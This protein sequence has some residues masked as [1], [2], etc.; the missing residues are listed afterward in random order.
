MGCSASAT[1]DKF[2]D[3]SANIVSSDEIHEDELLKRI[4]KLEEYRKGQSVTSTPESLIVFGGTAANSKEL[5]D[6]VWQYEFQKRTWTVLNCFGDAPLSRAFHSAVY[7][8]GKLWIIG[9]L[10]QNA[11]HSDMYCM[12]LGTK[13][14]Q[15]V[16]Q[17][18]HCRENRA[19]AWNNSIIIVHDAEVGCRIS[20]SRYDIGAGVW[21][22]DS[23]P[24]AELAPIRP[25][26]TLMFAIV[27]SHLFALGVRGH[28]LLRYELET[29]VW[30]SLSFSG[31]D[32]GFGIGS[33]WFSSWAGCLWFVFITLLEAKPVMYLY[34][35]LPIEEGVQNS[36]KSYLRRISTT[37]LLPWAQTPS[38]LQAICQ[39]ELSIC[40]TDKGI[41]N[42]FAFSYNSPVL[43][44]QCG[45][46]V[47]EGNPRR[48]PSLS[49]REI[50]PEPL[51]RR[52]ISRPR[53]TRARTRSTELDFDSELRIDT[54][55][56]PQSRSASNTSCSSAGITDSSASSGLEG[57]DIWT[58]QGH[59]SPT[60]S[61][62]V[63]RNSALIDESSGSPHLVLRFRCNAH[64][65]SVPN[66]PPHLHSPNF[67]NPLHSGHLRHRATLPPVLPPRPNPPS[68]SSHGPYRRPAFCSVSEPQ[69]S[70]PAAPSGS[71]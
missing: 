3:F 71:V 59:H 48:S 64:A 24:F 61:V 25:D 40:I 35:I 36:F 58:P 7:H 9:G 51:R 20:V 46:R 32:V 28:T 50:V 38:N 70:L 26:D 31:M 8:S 21:K 6:Q 62:S 29:H 14:W 41:L 55:G 10:S 57:V 63:P 17:A 11:Q 15:Y 34:N 47:N 13:R 68:H 52:K 44:W 43:S 67:R 60:S 39:D 16:C 22:P 49:S 54:S 23:E 66:I 4:G 37:K 5:V 45:A 30:E 27:G 56:S 12:D 42:V 69:P 2:Q 18:K 53:R 19:F 65:T 33:R 1:K